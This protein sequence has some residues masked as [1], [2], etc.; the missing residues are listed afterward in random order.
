[1]STSKRSFARSGR[2]FGILAFLACVVVAVAAVYASDRVQD[3]SDAPVATPRVKVALAKVQRSSVPSVITG[4]GELEAT[5]QVRV[6]AEVG[7]R[8]TKISFESGQR[9]AA[10]QLLVQLND[11]P[12]QAECIRRKAQL[13]NAT[14]AYTRLRSLVTQ[15][16]ATQEQLDAALAA[17]DMALG[18]LQH[19]EALIAQK[20]IRAPF[21]GVI[22]IRGVHEGQYLD[23]GDPVASLVDAGVLHVNFSLNE[24]SSPLL[25]VGQS[26]EVGIDAYPGRGFQAA[27][28]AIDPWI[29]RSRLIQVQATMTNPDNLLKAGMYAKIQV[30]RHDT[31]SV[32]TIP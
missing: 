25:Q 7:G 2:R 6:A 10:D 1:M 19:V 11:A 26:V 28:T 13:R 21:S 31:P 15:N 12:E 16:A 9:V 8:V 17:R 4:I 3:T 18:E 30:A 29:D 32:L 22:G 27:V 20:A 14:T 5:R 24:Q 23:T